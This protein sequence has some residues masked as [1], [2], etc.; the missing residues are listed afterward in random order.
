MLAR[1]QGHGNHIH[2]RGI[3][4]GLHFDQSRIGT[5]DANRHPDRVG[6]DLLAIG[7]DTDFIF[8]RRGNCRLYE[9]LAIRGHG[10]GGFIRYISTGGAGEF[11]T[12]KFNRLPFRPFGDNRLVE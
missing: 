3:L 10:P 11:G 9:Y 1:A 6:G 4:D 2:L 7:A 12:V 5:V 8:T